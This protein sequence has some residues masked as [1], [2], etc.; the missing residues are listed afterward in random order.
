MKEGG[1]VG[2]LVAPQVL[3]LQKRLLRIV[4][5]FTLLCRRVISAC[6]SSSERC[7]GKN[8]IAG[9]GSPWAAR[10]GW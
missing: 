4:K 6:S 8:A 3:D 1:K 9:G 7:C 10:G 2:N 5:P